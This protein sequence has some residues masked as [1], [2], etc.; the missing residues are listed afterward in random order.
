MPKEY[1]MCSEPLAT[2]CESFKCDELSSIAIYSPMRV[3]TLSDAFYIAGCATLAG[4][5]QSGEHLGT[6]VSARLALVF[7]QA[8]SSRMPGDLA[9]FVGLRW[10]E[11]F[12]PIAFLRPCVDFGSACNV[13]EHLLHGT[14]DLKDATMRFGV[15]VSYTHL[16]LPT[17]RIV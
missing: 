5:V 14:F 12:G 15:S 4:C 1:D 17:K 10:R 6:S 11:S 16:T 13:I 7:R 8:L 3:R 2:I 9:A